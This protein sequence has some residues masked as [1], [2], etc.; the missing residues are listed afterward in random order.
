M[1]RDPNT[2]LGFEDQLTVANQTHGTQ[3]SYNTQHRLLHMKG[4]RLN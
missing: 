2:I 4:N 3:K 1:T